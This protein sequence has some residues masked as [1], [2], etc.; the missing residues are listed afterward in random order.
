MLMHSYI[1][2]WL[3]G[4]RLYIHQQF[5]LYTLKLT[6][7][8]KSLNTTSVF[9]TQND[10]WYALCPTKIMLWRWW[11]VWIDICYQD[12]T[13]GFVT[14]LKWTYDIQISREWY[15]SLENKEALSQMF[16]TAKPAEPAI[17]P[18]RTW[19]SYYSAWIRCLK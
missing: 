12:I 16:I 11:S 10:G 5:H 17:L 9:I 3:A 2:G 6:I 4:I 19:Q 8:Q 15:F 1:L 14:S 13:L 7:I 18:S